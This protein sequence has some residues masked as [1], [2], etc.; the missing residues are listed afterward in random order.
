MEKLAIIAWNE[1]KIGRKV[2]N[3]FMP[4]IKQRISYKDENNTEFS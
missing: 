1:K 4:D 3:I 2:W